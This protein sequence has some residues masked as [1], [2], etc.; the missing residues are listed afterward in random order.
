MTPK[1]LTNKGAA[2]VEYG[3]LVGLVA[4]VAIGSVSAT[5]RKV[6][7]VFTGS[8]TAL[9]LGGEEV[10]TPPAEAPA[11]PFS[12]G[13]AISIHGDSYS[14]V[15]IGAQCWTGENLN[16]ATAGSECYGNVDANCDTYGRL[17]PASDLTAGICG[18]DFRIPKD[19]DWKA[20]EVHLGMS[21]SQSD[22]VGWRP[23]GQVGADLA[24]W[25]PSGTNNTGFTALRG[26]RDTGGGYQL[27]GTA[28]FF[29]AQPVGSDEFYRVINQAKDDTYRHSYSGGSE[30]LSLRCMMDIPAP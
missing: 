22:A 4:V 16:F 24:S 28:A 21:P 8:A 1:N 6:E 27:I 20:L 14:T 13:D 7:G 10:E 17:Y 23:Q 18:A 2:L 19:D 25:T 3:L 9:A 5:G 12:C 26:G 29:W 15:A 30:R 11:A